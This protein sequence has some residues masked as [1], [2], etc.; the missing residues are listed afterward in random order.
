MPEHNLSGHLGPGKTGPQGSLGLVHGLVLLLA[1]I[2]VQQ[3]RSH[4]APGFNPNLKVGLFRQSHP[5][6]MC[7]ASGKAKPWDGHE[8]E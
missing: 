6:E 3:R 8:G 1:E 5:Q 2:L 4:Q 7:D